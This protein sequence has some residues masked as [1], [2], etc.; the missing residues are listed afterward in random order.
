MREISRNYEAS[1]SGSSSPSARDFAAG[2][3]YCSTLDKKSA[4]QHKRQ[5]TEDLR[6]VPDSNLGVSHPNTRSERS[7]SNAGPTHLKNAV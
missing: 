4:I 5:R 6:S 2:K 3:L 1:S 7:I